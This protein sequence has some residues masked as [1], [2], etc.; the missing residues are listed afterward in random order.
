MIKLI[1]FI[2]LLF[3]NYQSKKI[4]SFINLKLKNAEIELARYINTKFMIKKLGEY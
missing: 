4:L 2:I 1:K 3:D